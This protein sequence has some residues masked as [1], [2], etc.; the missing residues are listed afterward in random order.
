MDATDKE[1]PKKER[2]KRKRSKKRIKRERN[3]L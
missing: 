2:K 3:I 1:W